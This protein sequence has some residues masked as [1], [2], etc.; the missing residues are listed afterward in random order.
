MINIAK[1]S[2]TMIDIKIMVR[3]M[4]YTLLQG[5]FTRTNVTNNQERKINY[6]MN[7][8]NNNLRLK[9]TKN[10]DESH[11][12]QADI[13]RVKRRYNE[14]NIRPAFSSKILIYSMFC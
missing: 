14:S 12:L 7:S 3:N 8:L 13:S 5:Q 4:Y 9:D 11:N 6:T 1:R 10:Q 2:E